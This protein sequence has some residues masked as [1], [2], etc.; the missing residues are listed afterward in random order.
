M[1]QIDFWKLHWSP[2]EIENTMLRVSEDIWTL[3]V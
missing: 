2:R 1:A 3:P